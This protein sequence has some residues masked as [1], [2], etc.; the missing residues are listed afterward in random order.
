MRTRMGDNLHLREPLVVVMVRFVV[1]ERR[2]FVRDEIQVL[3]TQRKLHVGAVR[4]PLQNPLRFGGHVQLNGG[5]VA[6]LLLRDRADGTRVQVVLD[7]AA[8]ARHDE[9]RF[10]WL[11]LLFGQSYVARG[12]QIVQ[13]RPR[14]RKERAHPESHL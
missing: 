2:N 6:N 8:V 14:G 3:Q 7:E 4:L 11:G 5:V 13:P 10:Y 9:E 12:R 1:F